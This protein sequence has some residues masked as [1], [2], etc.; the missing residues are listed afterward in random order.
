MLSEVFQKGLDSVHPVPSRRRGAVK[1][2]SLGP[3]QPP[4][5]RQQGLRLHIHVT[6][7]T[8]I[9]RFPMFL[10]ADLFFGKS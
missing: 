6:H 7:I 9:L 3:Y 10:V 2:A 8:R 5:G 4:S 1:G